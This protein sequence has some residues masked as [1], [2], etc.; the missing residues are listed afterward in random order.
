MLHHRI[1]NANLA[2]HK[3]LQVT[4]LLF[5]LSAGCACGQTAYMFGFSIYNATCLPQT[6]TWHAFAGDSGNVLNVGNGSIAIGAGGTTPIYVS[7]VFSGGV[8]DGYGEAVDGAVEIA[9]D[10]WSYGQPCPTG[11]TP[12]VT[13]T[14]GT[15]VVVKTIY[16]PVYARVHVPGGP[17]TNTLVRIYK[18]TVVTSP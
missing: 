3:N 18:K 14:I 6:I 4:V 1:R 10:V 5:L 17:D 9:Q 11:V 15:N 7:G 16:M 2:G 13:N 8:F 12:P